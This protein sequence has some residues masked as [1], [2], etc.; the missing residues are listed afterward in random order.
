MDKQ[1]AKPI[2]RNARTAI[3]FNEINKPLLTVSPAHGGGWLLRFQ[4]DAAFNDDLKTILPWY[5]RR[6]DDVSQAWWID[7]A[8]L[9]GVLQLAEPYFAIIHYWREPGV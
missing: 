3:A 5:A 8:W 1:K 2:P 6:W 9:D 4:Y 7:S